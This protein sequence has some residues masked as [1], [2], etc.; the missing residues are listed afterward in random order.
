MTPATDPSVLT[1]KTRPGP[2]IAG[3]LR[4]DGDEQRVH[5]RQHDE[6]N[7]QQDG[8]GQDAAEHQVDAGEP[9]NSQG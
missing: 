6:R 7:R 3:G 1:K 4:P 5:G 2:G 9:G 8:G